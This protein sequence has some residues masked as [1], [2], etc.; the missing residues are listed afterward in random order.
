M[1]PSTQVDV[2]SFRKCTVAARQRRVD[3]IFKYHIIIALEMLRHERKDRCRR[4]I[5]TTP[6]RSGELHEFLGTRM[7]LNVY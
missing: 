6:N 4:K 1:L 5:R 7:T 3:I 2:A